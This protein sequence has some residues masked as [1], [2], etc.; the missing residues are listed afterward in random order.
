MIED[1]E[2]WAWAARPQFSGA[3]SDGGQSLALSAQCLAHSISIDLLMP[4]DRGTCDG[5]VDERT[6]RCAS[7]V[8][9][10]PHRAKP[11]SPLE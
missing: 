9:T 2:R 1:D 10:Q 11:G 7:S 4:D 3:L 6:D 5:M 8:G